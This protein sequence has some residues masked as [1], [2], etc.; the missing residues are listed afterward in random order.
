M[1]KVNK[2]ASGNA[3]SGSR[4]IHNPELLIALGLLL[5]CTAHAMWCFSIGWNNTLNDHHSFR[6]SQTAITAYYLTKEPLKLAYETPILGKPWSIPM[7]FPIY[8]WIVARFSNGTGIALDQAG[9][10]VAAGFY[11][12]TM[13][14]IY[15]L[16]RVRQVAIS[17]ALLFLCIPL[18]SP[19]YLYWSRAFMIESTALFFSF[20]YLACVMWGEKKNSWSILSLAMLIG[21]AAGLGKVTTWL[22]FL[23]LAGIWL[24]RGYL[25]WPLPKVPQKD[26]LNLIARI[27]LVCG[28]PF[29]VA[30]WWVHYS[31]ALK[32]IHPLAVINTSTNSAWWNYGTLAQKLSLDVWLAILSRVF[33]LVGLPT[34]AWFIFGCAVIAIVL[35]RRRWMEF[36]VLVILFLLSPAIFTNLHYIHDYYMNENGLFLLCAVGFAVMALLESGEVRAKLC[37]WLLILFVL[38]SGFSSQAE[39]PYRTLQETPNGEI[40]QLTDAIKKN[41]PQDSVL[42]ILGADWNPLVPYYSQRRSLLIPDWENL[43]E[44]QVQQALENLK[45][46]KIGALLVCES[47]R[48]SEERLMQQAK[49]AGLDF[50]VIRCGQLPLR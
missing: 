34:Q 13:I 28:I 31:D 35:T 32:G 43:T 37:G 27:F 50:P 49:A 45:G 22:P 48:Y 14:P 19:F 21:I 30:D 11:L 44:S 18:I 7:E 8:Q 12:L 23:A 26:L 10:S 15:A 3:A 33:T 17:H 39:L 24:I 47:H 42:I 25:R 20:C 1:N 2:K 5:F 41:T 16:L 36:L 29:F 6:Q 38:W 4:K 40:L 46:E 9:R